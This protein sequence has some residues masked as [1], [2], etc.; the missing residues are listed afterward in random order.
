[1]PIISDPT[2]ED[3]D[4][5]LIG[6]EEEI[7]IGLDPLSADTDKDTIIDGKEMLLGYDP[8]N[9]NPDGDEYRDDEEF[10]K[11]T[12]PFKQDIDFT[13]FDHIGAVTY[14]A[15]FGDYADEDIV[16]AE[17]IIG[18]IG[19]S[20]I[21]VVSVAADARDTVYNASS[22]HWLM[23]GLSVAGIVPVI[24]D[25]SKAIGNVGEAIVKLGDDAPAIA[26]L[27]IELAEKHPKLIKAFSEN[28]NV[29]EGI[30]KAVKSDSITK[31]ALEKILKYA[32]EAG[33]SISKT[34]DL[35]KDGDNV[36]DGVKDVWKQ[37]ACKR[38][39]DIDEFRNLHSSNNGLGINFPVFDRVN[40]DTKTIISTKSLDLGA[41][42]YKDPE[43]L[44]KRLQKYIDQ[45]NDFEK[46]YPKVKNQDGFKW[47]NTI[48]HSTEYT[49]KKLELV[50][51]DMP[52]TPK[53]AQVIQ[54][55]I[56]KHKISVIIM[57]G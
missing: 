32:D 31:E 35:F 3:S 52:I 33:I 24:G 18:Q 53:Q 9:P 5:D 49:S 34:S 13:V 14:G 15:I 26:K 41:I 12:D 11:G 10:I 55:F 21:P 56:D 38:G 27:I 2:N 44:R 4:Y 39:A 37:G 25:A 50:I 51:P 16:N 30:K 6:D 47:G 8:F 57:K 17:V 29:V 22:H 46:K 1:M 20:F 19:G 43:K 45:M 42:S 54:E 40:K 23:T 28:E 48:L 36:I 7:V